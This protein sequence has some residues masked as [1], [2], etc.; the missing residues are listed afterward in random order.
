MRIAVVLLV[1]HSL[2]PMVLGFGISIKVKKTPDAL[3]AHQPTNMDCLSRKHFCST[4]A[5][6]LA[7]M[8]SVSA[9]A[10]QASS[11]ETVAMEMKDFIDP[12]GLFSIRI[13]KN[14]FALRRSTKGDLPDENTGKG[15]RG[16]SIFTAGDMSK[17]EVIAIERYVEYLV[18]TFAWPLYDSYLHISAS[19]F[20]CCLKRTVSRLRAIWEISPTLASRLQSRIF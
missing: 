10:V 19:Q 13:P 16:S 20:A 11:Y 15:R 7:S 1:V 18:F 8:W 4:A 12:L 9:G 17:A 5:A 3:W 14:F 6:S 2:S